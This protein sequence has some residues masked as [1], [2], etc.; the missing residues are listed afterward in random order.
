[1]EATT[2]IK[3]LYPRIQQIFL[4]PHSTPGTIRALI[5][6]NKQSKAP[7]LQEFM[8]NMLQ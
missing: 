4:S 7:T 6:N 2:P 1:M 3:L 8:G 5:Q